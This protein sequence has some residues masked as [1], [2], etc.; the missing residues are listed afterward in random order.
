[1]EVEKMEKVLRW[2][3]DEDDNNLSQKDVLGKGEKIFTWKETALWTL[4]KCGL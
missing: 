4:Q 1:M 3:T 2:G